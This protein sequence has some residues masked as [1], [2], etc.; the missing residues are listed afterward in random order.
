MAYNSRLGNDIIADMFL[1]IFIF[2]LSTILIMRTY[3]DWI[4]K[5]ASHTELLWYKR[6]RKFLRKHLGRIN[7][8]SYHAFCKKR[9]QNSVKRFQVYW[10]PT[11][12]F[13][14]GVYSVFTLIIG[15][16]GQYMFPYGLA[17]ILSLFLLKIVDLTILLPIGFWLGFRK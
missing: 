14:I 4:L 16:F 6:Q 7:L 2:A 1:T 15:A 17:V 3:A 11:A 9:I 13:F 12:I 10:I 8:A 5:V